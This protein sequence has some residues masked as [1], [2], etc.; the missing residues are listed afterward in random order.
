MWNPF[1]RFFSKR[2]LGIDVGTSYVKVVELYKSGRL[3]RLENYGQVSSVI[4]Q[5]KPFRVSDKS[6]LRLSN[7]EVAQAITSIINEAEIKTK[8]AIFSIPDFSSFFTSFELPPMT[9]EE[10]S[11]AVSYE[12][13]QHIPL[14]LSEVVLDWQIIKSTPVE[15]KKIKYKILLVAVPNDVI[16]Q[17]QEIARLSQLELVA[18]EAEV[19]SLMRSLAKDNKTT[20]PV[21]IVDIGAK[22]TTC[23]VVDEG[24]IKTSHSFDMS[25]NDLTAALVKEFQVDFTEAGKVKKQYG[26]ESDAGEDSQAVSKIILP[27]IEA[28]AKEIKGVLD[29]FNKQEKKEVKKIIIVGGTA[30]LPG[31]KKYFE[32]FFV[33]KKIEIGNPF[34]DILH[35]AILEEALA[36]M[37]PS[38]AIATGAALR[39]L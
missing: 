13:R 37:G 19:F 4:F 38:F 18:L 9:R 23:T 31:L 22:T 32:E 2:L 24:V 25:G 36:D 27:P 11:E 33:G 20:G 14:P 5:R 17:Y 16:N 29:S 3:K 21:A 7:Q 15:G 26:I 35:P 8:Q 39:G 12:A 10:L 30:L 34:S 28:I 1:Q 6:T